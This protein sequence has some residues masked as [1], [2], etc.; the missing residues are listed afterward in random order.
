MASS[1]KPPLKVLVADYDLM[2]SVGGG[3]T[4]YRRLFQLLPEIRFTYLRENEAE[5]VA[6]PGNVSAIRVGPKFFPHHNVSPEN[7][8]W[9]HA[10]AA[11]ERIARSIAGQSHD[12]LEIPDYYPHYMMLPAALRRHGVQ[13]RKVVVALHGQNSRSLLTSWDNSAGAKRNAEILSAQ[14]LLLYESADVRWGYSSHNLAEWKA[15]SS[16][17][18]CYVSPLSFLEMP[19]VTDAKPASVNGTPPSLCFIGRTERRKGPDLFLEML[20]RLPRSSYSK[21]YVIG[22][23]VDTSKGMD[24]NE[25]LKQMA[26]S[27]ELEVEFP[28]VM[29]TRQL[30]EVFAGRS[31]VYVPSRYD[32]LNLVA[33][34]SL[35]AGCPTFVGT[36]AGACQLLDDEL[37]SIPFSRFELDD[38]DLNVRRTMELS[39][40][41]DEARRVL[42]ERL[43]GVKCP[44]TKP[45]MVDVYETEPDHD[46]RSRDLIA[47]K[48]DEQLAIHERSR[49]GIVR[50]VGRK[51]LAV[52]PPARIFGKFNEYGQKWLVACV[53]WR[54]VKSIERLPESS[55]EELQSKIRAVEG[56]VCGDRFGRLWAWK[57]LS[58]LEQKA[59]RDLVAATYALR[60]LRLSGGDQDGL[61]PYVQEIL[62]RNNFAQEAELV[63]LMYGQPDDATRHSKLLAWLDDHFERQKVN[64]AV[65]FE[66]VDDRRGDAT[67]KV[68]I[69]VSLYNAAAKTRQFLDGLRK[70]TLLQWNE[71]E[72]IFVDS[73]SPVDEYRPIAEHPCFASIPLVYV[74]TAQRETIQQAWNRGLSI[75]KAPYVTMLGVDETIRPTCLELLSNELDRRPEL[76]WIQ[77]NSLV[78]ETDLEGR[79]DRDLMFYDRHD[80]DTELARLECCYLSWV[81]ALY[82]RNIHDR[83]GYYDPTF[84]AAGD[85]EFKYRLLPHL[86]TAAYP[87][88]LGLFWN[89]PDGRT[90]QHPRAEIEDYRAWHVF[91]SSAGVE[92]AHRNSS[93]E[94]IL[95]AASHA[96]KYRVSYRKV[97]SADVEYAYELLRYAHRRDPA[98][99]PAEELKLLEQ[100]LRDFRE[101]D[102]ADWLNLQAAIWS[103]RKIMSRLRR[104]NN[105][106]KK[107]FA[108]SPELTYFND[109]R[110]E[111]INWFWSGLI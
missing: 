53:H 62:T 43:S 65:P 10:F 78:V 98:C 96:L 34:E 26:R 72:L 23:A 30:A 24:S 31:I 20:W 33:L 25:L 80:Y 40:N 74:R 12:V 1:T 71:V 77:S 52:I 82:R 6:L 66:R 29:T 15:I 103:T 45:R 90:T 84:R 100:T 99:F 91:R 27:R 107:R 19:K 51:V 64:P 111:H 58:R 83:F 89:Y 108:N 39:K 36:G 102:R 61:L 95:R 56:V 73:G 79:Y 93:V 87:H 94:T 37:P 48:Y 110:C 21:A 105:Q 41:Y 5:S 9:I 54:W 35:F 81:G 75:A 68:A 76:D 85:N 13:I 3:Q 109:E 104:T 63:N 59:G 32:T 49:P 101:L 69:I 4:V 28:G 18:G 46:S 42:V 92:Y 38:L 14:E 70:Q 2:S 97:F 7:E 47:E 11:C 55:P 86:K 106:L 16:R 88:T 8:Q 44:L 57:T 60:V 67:A 22:G 50:K 17:P